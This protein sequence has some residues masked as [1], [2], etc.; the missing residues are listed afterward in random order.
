MSKFKFFWLLFL[1]SAIALAVYFERLYWPQH[2]TAMQQQ[3]RHPLHALQYPQQEQPQTYAM[4]SPLNRIVFP[5]AHSPHKDYRHEWWYLTANLTNQA[6]QPFAAQWTLFRT[7]VN[8][9]HLYFAHAALADANSHQFAQRIGSEEL[10]NVLIS[11]KPFSA[12]IDD[13]SWHSSSDLLPAQVNFGSALNA[14]PDTRWQAS[15]SLS[16]ATPFYLQGNQGFNKKHAVK[17]IA[18]HYYSQPF[19][20]VSGEIFFQ[21]E[22]Q[23][24]TGIAWFDREWGSVMLAPEQQG[25]DWFSLHLS[26]DSALMV[27]RIRQTPQD[28]IYAS[29][30]HKSGAIQRLKA[31]DIKLVSQQGNANDDLLSDPLSDPISYPLSFTLKI[32]KHDINI[33][34]TIVNKKQIMKTSFEYFEGMVNF[35]GSH[36]GVGFVEMTGYH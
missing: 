26:N 25:W 10:G 18:S 15:L 30:M 17:N 7:R 24:V 5:L 19:I 31:A 35:S 8:N 14:A 22:L 1:V 28:F 9:R 34:I 4:P 6:G 33:I 11:Q 23:Q 13:W 32:A 21:G 29:I 12:L 3:G 2:N 20:D 36:S 27:Y 16:N